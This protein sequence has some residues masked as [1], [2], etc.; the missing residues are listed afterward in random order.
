MKK[1]NIHLF[2]FYSKFAI[3]FF[4]FM[5]AC[6]MTSENNYDYPNSL[7]RNPSS[8]VIEWSENG[9]MYPE[10]KNI[11]ISLDSCYYKIRKNQNQTSIY[12]TVSKDELEEIYSYFVRNN[13]NSI[14]EKNDVEVYD[15]GGTSIKLFVDN[16][17]IEKKNSG[18]TFLYGNNAE[19]YRN[20]EDSLLQFVFSKIENKY[21]NIN[22]LI[23]D[24]IYSQD[25]Y[26]FLS[27]NEETLINTYDSILPVKNQI[28]LFP[29]IHEIDMR[30]YSKDTFD[31]N[32]YPA[33]YLR[34]IVQIEVSEVSSN[35]TIKF[36]NNAFFIE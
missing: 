33:L 12:F 27:V 10:N 31:Y 17:L 3:A 36:G 8:V 15:R 11:Y 29:G 34:S 35:F 14:R 2:K 1:K 16:N 22:F 7:P 32:R 4:A 24:F 6:S 19:R 9:G 13:F 26:F 21:I 23:D 20:I 28:R 25:K 5:Q 18:R 30:Y